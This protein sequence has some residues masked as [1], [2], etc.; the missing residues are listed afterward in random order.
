MCFPDASTCWGREVG[1]KGTGDA[2]LEVRVDRVHAICG[3][4]EDALELF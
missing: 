2:R 3:E 4:K 1:V